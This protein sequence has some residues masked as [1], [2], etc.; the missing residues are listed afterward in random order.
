M[1][2]GLKKIK[3]IIKDSFA[4]DSDEPYV[5]V[6]TLDLKRVINLGLE[7]STRMTFAWSRIHPQPVT[8]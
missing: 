8:D 7:D 4:A 6:F 3:C 2:L 1:R 5:L